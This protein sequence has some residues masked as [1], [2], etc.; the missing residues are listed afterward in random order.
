MYIIYMYLGAPV[1]VVTYRTS[2]TAVFLRSVGAELE[3]FLNTFKI[4]LT[5]HRK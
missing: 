2:N 5:G 4:W 3:K 1:L